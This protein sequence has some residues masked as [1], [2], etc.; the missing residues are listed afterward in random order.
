MLTHTRDLT[1]LLS[2][3]TENKF[4]EGHKTA[5]QIQQVKQ[6]YTYSYYIQ[7]RAGQQNTG[8]VVVQERVFF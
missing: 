5:K 3:Y 7:T 4:T 6:T 8:Q 2:S 1:L